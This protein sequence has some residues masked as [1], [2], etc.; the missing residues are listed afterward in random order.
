MCTAAGKR[1]RQAQAASGLTV[2]MRI[3]TMNDALRGWWRIALL[4]HAHSL[5]FRRGAQVL[6]HRPA[7]VRARC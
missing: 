1:L 7:D 4:K 6:R 2:R 5:L 3:E